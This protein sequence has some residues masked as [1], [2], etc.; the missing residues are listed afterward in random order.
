MKRMVIDAGGVEPTYEE[1]TWSKEGYSDRYTITNAT[2]VPCRI[3]IYDTDTIPLY[4]SGD[5]APDTSGATIKVRG[6]TSAYFGL[7]KPYKIKLQK[8]ADL[9]F[10]NDSIDHRDKNWVLL[11]YQLYTIIGF[12]INELLDLPYKVQC[13]PIAVELN[14]MAIGNYLLAECISRNPECR[15]DVEKQSGYIIERDAYWWKEPVSFTSTKFWDDR[16]HWTFKYPDADEL[17]S[18]RIDHIQGEVNAMEAS[19]GSDNYPDYIDV[20]SYAAWA[21]GQDLLGIG[22]PEGSNAYYAK[23]DTT[24]NTR[25]FMPCLWDFDSMAFE[26]M[27]AVF[28]REKWQHASLFPALFQNTENREFIRC[29][30]EKW[31]TISDTIVPF[32]AERMQ[33]Y[34]YSMS[35][36][37]DRYSQWF[38]G[39]KVFMDEYVASLELLTAERDIQAQ[40]ARQ[41]EKIIHDGHLYI[42]CAHGTYDILGR[43]VGK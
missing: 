24:S 15:I 42:R 2:K 9:L 4:D 16:M 36:A 17:T 43:L 41:T 6:N 37:Y 22:D 31:H 13:E 23:K 3:Y 8:K 28:T 25:F 1:M 39:R 21:I 14:G 40:E 5:Y 12:A 19:L 11:H 34:Q 10:R 30:C 35:T 27:E 38:E 18:E 33:P 26:G 7:T 29:Y 32:V 20:T